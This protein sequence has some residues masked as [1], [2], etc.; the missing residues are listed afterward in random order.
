MKAVLGPNVNVAFQIKLKEY[1]KTNIGKVFLKE[2][3]AHEDSMK[4]PREYFCSFI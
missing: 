1:I 4:V 2:A 3:E